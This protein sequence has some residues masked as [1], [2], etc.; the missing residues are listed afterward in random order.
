MRATWVIWVRSLFLPQPSGLDW[1]E[2]GI[3]EHMTANPSHPMRMVLT[4]LIMLAACLSV[5]PT[6]AADPR[7]TAARIAAALD[8]TTWIRDGSGDRIVYFFFDPNC[9]HCNTAY[10]NIAPI[11]Q[12]EQDLQIRYVPMGVLLPSSAG[13]AAAIIQAADPLKAYHQMEEGYGFSTE[14]DGGAIAPAKTIL[15]ATREALDANYAIFKDNNIP[16]MPLIVFMGDDGRPFMMFGARSTDL[17]R[18][19]FA[20]IAPGPFGEGKCLNP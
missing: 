20:H 16:G 14:G 8:T 12:A 9:P 18:K 13:K 10:R 19:L 7:A 2:K 17:Y 6:Q 4:G 11:K 15:P 3:A 1:A 5:A